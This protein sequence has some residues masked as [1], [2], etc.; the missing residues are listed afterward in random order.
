MSIT[1]AF[2]LPA[3]EPAGLFT[4]QADNNRKLAKPNRNKHLFPGIKIFDK[5]RCNN[6]KKAF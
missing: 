2:E 3:L 4:A 1:A 5:N 6:L